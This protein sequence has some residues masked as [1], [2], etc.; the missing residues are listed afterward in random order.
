MSAHGALSL[1][2]PLAVYIS[3]ATGSLTPRLLTVPVRKLPERNLLVPLVGVT[4]HWRSRLMKAT[5]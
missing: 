1:N 3:M 5:V 4:T 2:A